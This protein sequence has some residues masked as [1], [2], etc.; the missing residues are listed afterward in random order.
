MTID[1]GLVN[2]VCTPPW[3][4]IF[5]CRPARRPCSFS[6]RRCRLYFS[7]RGFLPVA[8]RRGLYFEG[9]AWFLFEGLEWKAEMPSAQV[10]DTT[11]FPI[12]PIYTYSYPLTP[13]KAYSLYLYIP[14]S[15]CSLIRESK[16][17]QE[18]SRNTRRG[19]TEEQ[20]HKQEEHRKEGRGVSRAGFRAVFVVLS[21]CSVVC[22]F[23]FYCFILLFRCALCP[24]QASNLCPFSH[25]LQAWIFPA[26][27]GN[28]ATNP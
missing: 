5:S 12:S 6:P 15:S 17:I 3:G 10:T 21:C 16:E 20:E 8:G 13:Y 27:Y 11:P 25:P 9:V 1:S 26:L 14:C 2:G 23:R 28:M 24:I 18:F 22:L 7:F 19:T 4:D